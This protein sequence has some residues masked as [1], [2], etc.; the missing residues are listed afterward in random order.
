[1]LLS[2]GEL[3]EAT[4]LLD[5]AFES[6]LI[7]SPEKRVS[8]GRALAECYQR[9]TL[10]DVAGQ[11]YD[12]CLALTP[13]DTA[14]R[15]ASAEVWRLAGATDRATQ[16]LEQIDDG[17]FEAAIEIASL[18]GLAELAKP[19]ELADFISVRNAIREARS[20]FESLEPA[21]QANAP[22]WR[23][24]LFELAYSKYLNAQTEQAETDNKVLARLAEIAKRYPMESQV[25]MAAVSNF[26]SAGRITESDSAIS[27]LEAI[28]EKSQSLDDRANLE[29][30]KAFKFIFNDRVEEGVELLITAAKDVPE[31]QLEFLSLASDQLLRMEKAKEAYR[32]LSSLPDEKLKVETI[33][34]LAAI[35]NLLNAQDKKDIQ[36]D[37]S[38]WVKKLKTL[39]G[40]DGTHWRYLEAEAL[41]LEAVESSNARE[42]LTEATN[43]FNEIERIR[44]RW[45]RGSALGAR[46]ASLKGFSGEAVT[47]YRRA[48]RDGDRQVSTSMGL[49][50]ELVSLRRV[51]QAEGVL[52]QMQELSGSTQHTFALAEIFEK[53]GDYRRAIKLA[54]RHSRQ[55]PEDVSAKILLSRTLLTASMAPATEEKEQHELQ[56]GILAGIS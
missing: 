52:L 10:W 32:L 28:A 43:L 36:Q 30:A 1:M 41:L 15:Q 49:V 27:N 56:T 4:E 22:I 13:N 50:N 25:Q 47:L 55:K 24:E 37:L 17:T 33:M 42:L 46:I 31:K 34:S 44:P 12:K 23:L 38:R 6:P 9:R 53:K 2:S 39:E 29:I 54:R 45:G 3:I 21:E 40:P 8:A 26:A 48:I 11:V 18:Q 20:R 5:Q 7:I 16:R 51:D 19:R 35:S 14:L